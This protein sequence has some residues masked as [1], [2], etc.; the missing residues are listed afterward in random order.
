MAIVETKTYTRPN[1]SVE[2]WLDLQSTERLEMLSLLNPFTTAGNLV[3]QSTVSGDG[4]TQTATRTV[5]TLE[6]YAN[7]LTTFTVSYN[8]LNKDYLT[9]SNISVGNFAL[10]GVGTAFTANVTI[11]FPT[12][13]TSAQANL[14]SY[15][16]TIPT[17]HLAN[18]TV[19]D[20]SVT[21]IINYSGDADYSANPSFILY[22]GS[23]D[24][25]N[26]A[27]ATKSIQLV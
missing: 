1:T 8:K 16:N 7:Y 24:D 21:R 11:S 17:T 19:T 5:D 27:G 26:S 22:D 12:A 4:L 14:L 13:N 23:N 25:L 6:T 10:T 15:V 2:F 9:T 18:V 20:T 3:M